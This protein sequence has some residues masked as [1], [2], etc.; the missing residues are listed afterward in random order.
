MP[1]MATPGTK[2]TSALLQDLLREKKAQSQ[3]AKKTHDPANGQKNGLDDRE[4]QSSPIAAMSPRDRLDAHSRR[5]SGVG[6]RK[7]M[8]LKEMQEHISKMSK[9]NFNLKLE[10][11][12]CRER[13]KTLETKIEKF[14]EL[15]AD[16]RELQSINEELMSELET[17][18]VA[19]EQ[20]V[21]V[22]CER[23]ATI[24]ELEAKNKELEM[25]VVRMDFSR[26]LDSSDAEP[27]KE[28][29]EVVASPLS[30]IS[31]TELSGSSHNTGIGFQTD[32]Q[33]P[34]E[35]SLS[36]PDT[37]SPPKAPSARRIPSFM[38]DNKKSTTVLRSLYSTSNGNPSFVSLGRPVSMFSSYDDDDDRIDR[39][40][41][42]S[43]QL[44]ILSESGFESIYGGRKDQNPGETD[45]EDDVAEPHLPK[46][47]SNPPQRSAQS[48]LRLRRWL[49]EKNMTRTPSPKGT[50][51]D[52]VSSIGEVLSQAPTSSQDRNATAVKVT[53]YPREQRTPE[54]RQ[55]KQPRSHE[56]RSS[57]PSFAGPIFGAAVL[58]PT[59]DTMSTAT[60]NANSS[61]ASIITEKSLLDYPA[62]AYPALLP[63][64][65]PHSSEGGNRSASSGSLRDTA[66]PGMGAQSHTRGI[67]ESDAARRPSF[68]ISG[69]DMF[70][71]G[72]SS[73]TQASRTLSYPSPTGRA[74][75]LSG[76][77]SPQSYRG[78]DSNSE[79]TVD[80]SPQE[81]LRSGSAATIM[82][83]RRTARD[84][85]RSP[86]S[87]Q[88]ATTPSPITALPHL[89]PSPPRSSSLRSKIVNRFS[90]SSTN[91]ATRIPNPSSNLNDTTPSRPPVTRA[92][93]S[94]QHARLPRPASL[95]GQHPVPNP[96]PSPTY[97]LKSMIP[98]EKDMLTSLE[99]YSAGSAR[100]VKWRRDGN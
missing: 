79:K 32:Q 98:D 17:R 14:Q 35:H 58:P 90:R 70:S 7:D 19:V 65:R 55:S 3:R 66:R 49:D 45:G 50:G 74:R 23:E 92:P 27:A 59:P 26:S 96:N 86:L 83:T 93:A 56:K 52:R 62:K 72:S 68:T 25:A 60:L 97:E 41:S 81:R 100:N 28:G 67:S 30:T 2:P 53:D 80:Q 8:G 82:P 69:A 87:P 37:L 78:S 43:P 5:D 94:T 51:D 20:A 33:P 18:I 63:D 36:A 1:D 16:N 85:H 12:Y 57:S 64:T 34:S 71:G 73:T 95:Y 22:I 75:R 61:T 42:N 24:E 38:R 6:I 99:R 88:E 21:D 47:P 40:M 76:Q 29:T 4:V 77:R 10:V 54:K 15:E 11:H 48:Q 91:N 13:N 89:A 84:D 46:L 44:S 31:G 39:Q 9:Q